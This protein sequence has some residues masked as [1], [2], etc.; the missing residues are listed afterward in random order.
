MMAKY[1]DISPG[2]SRHYFIN[3]AV[4]LDSKL[5]IEGKQIEISSEE[6]WRVVH[7][8]RNEIAAILVGANT[9]KVDNPSLLTNST[10]L[11]SGTELHH[12]LRIILD[13]KNLLS[14]KER[15]FN[16]DNPILVLRSES[17]AVDH[18]NTN[19]ILLDMHREYKTDSLDLIEAY[20][21]RHQI[22]GYI[23]IEGGSAVISS[24]ITHRLVERMRIFRSSK[25]LGRD[26]VDLYQ[27]TPMGHLRLL[28]S[29]EMEGGTE[30][31]YELQA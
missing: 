13:P 25:L 8:F 5:S 3:C 6:D 20:L 21:E 29:K 22:T 18:P 10:F 24:L 9:I 16:F 31:I 17:L 15:I 30:E 11:P 12:P 4:S 14:G 19:E 1:L 2:K 7:S 28:R 26:G 23:M 27:G